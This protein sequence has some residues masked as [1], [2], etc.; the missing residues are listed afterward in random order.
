MF[1]VAEDVDPEV[2][3]FGHESSPSFTELFKNLELPGCLFESSPDEKQS[4]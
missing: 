4:H 2:A 3:P 1:R